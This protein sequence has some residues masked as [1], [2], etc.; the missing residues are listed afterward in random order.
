MVVRSANFED[1]APAAHIMVT[2]FRAAF[3]AFV[4]PIKTQ[5]FAAKILNISEKLIPL[6]SNPIITSGII[7]ESK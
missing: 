5:N 3:A 6:I 2:S 7:I 1:M 4:S